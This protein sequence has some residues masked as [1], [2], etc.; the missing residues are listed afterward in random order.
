[1][2]ALR[3]VNTKKIVLALSLFAIIVWAVL[4][5]GA[6]VA[7]FHDTSP[8]IKNVFHFADFDLKVSHRL[9]DGSWEEVESDTKL[10]DEEALYE[11]GYTQ[12]VYLK[13][14][15]KGT[16]DFE[17]DMAVNFNNRV[18]AQNVFGQPL[19]LQDHL[20]FGVTSSKNVD[21]MKS[22]VL[23]REEASKIAIEPLNNYAEEDVPLEAKGTLYIALIVRMPEEIGNIAN[24]RGTA[25]PEVE[26][27]VIIEATQIQ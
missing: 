27:G 4:G 10:F 14:E 25:I 9:T 3:K 15:N 1:M 17:L 23:N 18:V 26:L 7:W 24:Y 12:V 5:T 13:I 22:S 11:P 21:E 6:S 8:K 19:I 16:V 20:R 2:K